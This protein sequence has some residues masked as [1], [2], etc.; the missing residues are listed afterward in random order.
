MTPDDQRHA[1]QIRLEG[2][3]APR[4]LCRFEGLAVTL[5]PEGETGTRLCESWAT[6]LDEAFALPLGADLPPLA[7][8]FL[9]CAA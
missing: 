5:L 6:R 9:E 4:W 7:A 3:L 2:H 8:L 1:Y